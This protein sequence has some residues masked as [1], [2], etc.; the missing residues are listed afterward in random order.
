MEIQLDE[1]NNQMTEKIVKQRNQSD[2]SNRRD[3]LSVKSKVHKSVEE[4]QLAKERKLRD[5]LIKKYKK[6]KS[7]V[8]FIYDI[9]FTNFKSKFYKLN[10]FIE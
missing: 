8:I 1:N 9:L 4:Y 2:S 5:N 6:E 7:K 10:D 3:S